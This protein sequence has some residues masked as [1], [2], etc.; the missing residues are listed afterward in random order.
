MFL[1]GK[2]TPVEQ[3]NNKKINKY[4]FK[5]TDAV[6]QIKHTKTLLQNE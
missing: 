2:K 1:L 3:P 4:M 5:G 6:R